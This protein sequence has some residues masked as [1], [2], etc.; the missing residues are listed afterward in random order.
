MSYAFIISN[1]DDK[2]AS[3]TNCKVKG[4]KLEVNESLLIHVHF[5]LTNVSRKI[6]FP[7]FQWVLSR[8]SFASRIF[9]FGGEDRFLVFFSFFKVQ[10]ILH[11]QENN[12]Y[13]L[14]QFELNM[15]AYDKT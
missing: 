3:L 8:F 6:A 7:A 5:T 2:K 13:N 12:S 9:F 11:F 4:E 14:I 15:I 10:Q 1:C